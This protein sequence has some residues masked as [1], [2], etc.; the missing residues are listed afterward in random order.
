MESSNKE[1]KKQS[2][3]L[4]L[5]LDQ[6][7]IV[8]TELVKYLQN[9]FFVLLTSKKH[10]LEKTTKD[11][12]HVKLTKK[13]PSIPNHPYS[14]IFIVYHKG[15]EELF[16]S[17]LKKA[18][19]DKAQCILLMGKHEYKPSLARVFLGLYHRTKVVVY[20]DLFGIPHHTDSVSSE[21][22]YEAWGE[23]KVTI[24]NMGISTFS[25]VFIEDVL[26][27]VTKAVGDLSERIFFAFPKHPVTKL[28]FAHAIQKVDPL[29]SI[30]FHLKKKEFQ[31]A[32]IP[33]GTY[34]VEN[35]Y[36]LAKRIWLVFENQGK[37]KFSA[38][39]H[40]EIEKHID[41]KH[42][43]TQRGMRKS[44]LLFFVSLF[45]SLLL[46][47]IIT[48]IAF[49][50][51]GLHALFA[52]KGALE[53]GNLTLAKQEVIV[54]HEMF[55]FAQ[56]SSVLLLAEASVLG[57]KDMALQLVESIDAAEELTKTTQTLL[58]GLTSVQSVFLKTS[59]NPK[60]DLQAGLNKVKSG[61]ITLQKIQ[62]EE[63]PPYIRDL[64][65]PKIK[66]LNPIINPLS[67]VIDVFPQVLGF[68]SDKSY[69]LLFQNNMELRPGGGFIG[70]YGLV[71]FSKG[72]VKNFLIH[73][74]YDADGQLKGHIEPQFAIR[75]YLPSVHLYLRDSNFD[76]DFGNSASTA[77]FLLN[78]ELNKQ[79]DGVFAVDVSFV[80]ELIKAVGPLYIPE[81]K[82]TVDKD[83]FYL[84]TQTHAEKNF[85]PGSTQKKD[86][87]F[88][89]FN[90]LKNKLTNEKA[91]YVPLIEA[92]G[93]GIEEKHVQFAFSDQT[94]HDL[95]RVNRL[96][97]S[98]WDPREDDGV[99]IP[100]Y[101]GISEAN[102]GVNKANYF[103]KR[104]IV[105]HT[106]IDENGTISGKVTI[107]YKNQSTKWP[108]GDYKNYLRLVVPLGT[109][110][111]SIEI[112]GTS[113]ATI[114]AITNPLVY[115]AKEF[116]PP[117]GLE[118]EEYQDQGKT[119]FGFLVIVPTQVL[120]TIVVSYALPQQ[121]VK[122]APLFTYSLYI[123]KQPGTEAYPYEFSLTYPSFMKIVG[124]LEG[125]LENKEGRVSLT[126]DVVKDEE[127]SIQF[128][129]Q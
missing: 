72:Q 55:S 116:V 67:A 39:K 26:A 37:E 43:K 79:V 38:T 8:G 56:S 94:I 107:M 9:E 45:V 50:A 110:I 87:L 80:R 5:I 21:L 34:V 124:K 91:S 3:S 1:P 119:V 10:F 19:L 64:V 100:D 88:S 42:K 41:E 46:S 96:H 101:L 127:I 35:P 36:P 65:L 61:L 125:G 31:D 104:K 114:S 105:Q 11:I 123:L 126:K 57:K 4:V 53:S 32:Y 22:L 102:L 69:L 63:N 47:P 33:D 120:K 66:K 90:A 106:S 121:I 52:T 30:D 7:G 40:N 70:S 6:E 76:L 86:F 85:F 28:S 12:G 89:V 118:V 128:S 25:P 15:I 58:D 98:L 117:T 59:K 18:E 49:S 95:F 103:V 13:I 24:P 44:V 51:I 23:K 82:E 111:T 92:L 14:H 16:Y 93:K 75:R 109:K 17:L 68:D 113:Q 77:A 54:S 48:T 62:L 71:D 78:Q 122:S 73:D 74:V 20:G 129:Q 99:T 108:G 112:D 97:S 84:L 29:V 60:E 83:N 2:K 81:Y 27:G 115:E